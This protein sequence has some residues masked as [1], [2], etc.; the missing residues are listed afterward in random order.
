MKAMGMMEREIT[1]LFLIES[2]GIGLL[3]SLG[4]CVLAALVNLYLVGVGIDFGALLGPD[5]DIGW[6][7]DLF[8]GV[9]NLGSYVFAFVF[10]IVVCL[11]VGFLPSRRAS[12]LDAV[13]ALSHV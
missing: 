3:G 2:G 13:E 11:V 8:R 1:T 10:G 9:W 7:I 5:F 4:G 6:P 12:R